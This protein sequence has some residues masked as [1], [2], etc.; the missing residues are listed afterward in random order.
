MGELRYESIVPLIASAREDGD[1][2][3]VGFCCP[4]TGILCEGVGRLEKGRTLADVSSERGLMERLR[5]SLFGRVFLGGT[6]AAGSPRAQAGEAVL[7][8]C[9][10]DGQSPYTDEERRAAA[11]EAFQ[12]VVRR[13]AWDERGQRWIAREGADA[14]LTD[15][16][17]Q[18]E[19]APVTQPRDREL[20][21]RM[22]TEVA[23]ADGRLTPKE[24]ELLGK[25]IPGDLSSV[26]TNMERPP[27]TDEELSAASGGASRDTMLMLAWALALTDDRVEGEEC[28]RVEEFARALKIPSERA[29]ELRRMAAGQ[30]LED[31]FLR[32]YP[33]RKPVPRVREVAYALGKRLG[34]SRGE[35]EAAERDFKRR[36]GLD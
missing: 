33:K 14:L 16:E 3:V 10:R 9:G 22:L 23:R 25:L 5:R 2:L 31:A 27:L 18:L 21:A 34:L 29:A 30:L 12:G 15:F 7:A 28:A 13:F 1:L 36:R 26:D 17:R 24:W 32:A 20:L 35:L 11:L 19:V 4:A 8:L 6:R